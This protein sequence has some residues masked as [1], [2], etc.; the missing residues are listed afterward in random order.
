MTLDDPVGA[1]NAQ[2]QVGQPGVI[3]VEAPPVQPDA[4][5]FDPA[6]YAL[7]YIVV[8]TFSTIWTLVIIWRA[9]L[10]QIRAGDGTTPEALDVGEDSDQSPRGGQHRLRCRMGEAPSPSLG[11]KII[12]VRYREATGPWW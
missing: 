2:A 12:C 3:E 6:D 7:F 11:H 8:L 9:V 5:P 10:K 4:P 1:G